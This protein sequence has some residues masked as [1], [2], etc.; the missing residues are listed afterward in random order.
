MGT[1]SMGGFWTLEEAYQV[2][3]SLRR[4][5]PTRL[6]VPTQVGSTRQGRPLQAW[7]L[8]D[9][10]VGCD[11]PRDTGGGGGDTGG[12]GGDTGGGDV[13]LLDRRFERLMDEYGDDEI[14]ELDQDDPDV[15][16]CIYSSNY[17]HAGGRGGGRGL[18]TGVWGLMNKYGD[19]EIGELDQDDPDVQV[20]IFRRLHR[21]GQVLMADNLEK[22]LAD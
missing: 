6:S 1:G 7:C 15:Q 19:D 4:A 2:L 20:I 14:G 9:G 8:T 18:N 11:L 13:R 16:V 10:L 3:E 22:L 12:G 17:F 21:R 5:H